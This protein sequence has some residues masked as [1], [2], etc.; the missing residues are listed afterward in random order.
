V[1]RDPRRRSKVSHLQQRNFQLLLNNRLNPL[2]LPLNL[3]HNQLPRQYPPQQLP[4]N[5]SIS[6]KQQPAQ[7]NNDTVSRA[8]ANL[9]PQPLVLALLLLLLL[10]LLPKPSPLALL[11]LSLGPPP[12]QQEQEQYQVL[13][14]SVTVLNSN[15]CGISYNQILNSSSLSS[16]I[17]HRGIH[18][19]SR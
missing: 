1:V 10:L 13:K 5:Q 3:Q 16:R 12:S 4:H 14:H 11:P 9:P 6:L 18:S 19:L 8:T 7:P 17:S 15:N 2:Q